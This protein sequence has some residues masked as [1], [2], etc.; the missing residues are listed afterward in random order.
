MSESQ[1]QSI[2][3]YVSPAD[4]FCRHVYDFLV[5]RGVAFA[6]HDVSENTQALRAMVELSGQHEAPVLV[7]DGQVYSA[8]D[9]SLLN[10]L[11]PRPGSRGVR[12]GIS[13]A[14]AKASGDRP[15]GA[16]VGEVKADTPADRAGIRKG[17]IIIEMGQRPVRRAQDV[18]TIA[19]ET[20]PGTRIPLTIWRARRKLRIMLG[21]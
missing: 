3:L 9:M 20:T 11:F 16:Y 17:D 12:L 8:F 4:P 21:V 19:S 10:R 1:P 13:I 7:V 18:H 6:V 15:A 2:M 14:S 5:R